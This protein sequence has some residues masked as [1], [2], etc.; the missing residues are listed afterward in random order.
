MARGSNS[1]RRGIRIAPAI[2][3]AGAIAAGVASS[4]GAEPTTGAGPT[5]V[6]DILGVGLFDICEIRVHPTGGVVARL[7][8]MSQGQGHATTLAQVCAAEGEAQPLLGHADRT[9]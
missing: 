6:C 5:K 4:K 2:A 8:T 9:P 1:L 3:I 7:G